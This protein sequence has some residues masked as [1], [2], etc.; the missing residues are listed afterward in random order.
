MFALESY[1]KRIIC[2]ANSRKNQGRCIAGLEF[3]G[4]RIGNWIRPVSG[5]SGEEISLDEARLADGNQPRVLDLLEVPLLRPSPKACQVENY[6]IAEE[7]TWSRAGRFHRTGLVAI[8]QDVEHLWVD[9]QSSKAGLND[10]ITIEEAD[11][12]D[13]SL[14]LVRPN[15]LALVVS[16]FEGRKRLRAHFALGG[17]K[18]RL[19]VTDP[20]V[21]NDFFQ[22]GVGRFPMGVES[23]LCVSLSEPFEG[24]RYKLVASVID[25][26]PEAED[27]P[28]ARDPE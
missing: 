7:R 10:R 5:R 26:R 8:C 24:F 23:V 25:C 11:R 22:L 3:D 19:I 15:W 14:A 12:L 21:E 2:L 18:Y 17:V 13:S 20:I 1:T 16:V 4:A 9:G 28:D 27:A 6:L